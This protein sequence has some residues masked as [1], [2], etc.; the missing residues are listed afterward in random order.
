MQKYE[1]SG[2]DDDDDDV[3]EFSQQAN[4]IMRKFRHAISL[5]NS[6]KGGEEVDACLDAYQEAL[7]GHDISG[8]FCRK[9]RKILKTKVG[10][11]LWLYIPL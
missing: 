6:S 3:L 8:K 9:W 7:D 1:E 10:G 4:K 2:G 5:M 11:I